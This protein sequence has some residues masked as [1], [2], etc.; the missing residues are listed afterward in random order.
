MRTVRPTFEYLITTSKTSLESFLC[1]RMNRVASLRKEARQILDELI[2]VEVD[3]CLA[4][5]ALDRRRLEQNACQQSQSTYNGVVRLAQLAIPFLPPAVDAM[6]NRDMAPDDGTCRTFPAEV[7]SPLFAD[8]FP[9]ASS[10]PL[11]E[12]LPAPAPSPSHSSNEPAGEALGLQIR[13]QREM[14]STSGAACALR[15]LQRLDKRALLEIG[16]ANLSSLTP[17]TSLVDRLA[18]CEASSTA[19]CRE[20]FEGKDTDEARSASPLRAHP[21]HRLPRR[22]RLA[23]A[24]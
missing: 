23:A 13:T 9:A 7:H 1:A 5:W 10:L 15:I 14:S 18:V 19:K 24:S 17:R 4:T 3:A 6:G 20:P 12:A 11:C 8:R 16:A 22:R 21:V 2:S